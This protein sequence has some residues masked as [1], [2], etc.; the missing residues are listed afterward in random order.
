MQLPRGDDHAR[1]LRAFHNLSDNP[2]MTVIIEWLTTQRDALDKVN[3]LPGHE[4]KVSAAFALTTILE[5][6]ESARTTGLGRQV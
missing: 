4:N 1:L 5:V 2:S 3:R 6:N